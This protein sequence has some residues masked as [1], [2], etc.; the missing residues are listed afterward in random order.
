MAPN[1]TT[2]SFCLTTFY[3]CNKNMHKWYC[4]QDTNILSLLSLATLQDQ[5]SCTNWLMS[6]T[7]QQREK[8]MITGNKKNGYKIKFAIESIICD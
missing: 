4:H 7:P 3:L 6:I 2:A 5:Q 8:Y 1:N